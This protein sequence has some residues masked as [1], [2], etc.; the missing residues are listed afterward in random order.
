M[1]VLGVEQSEYTEFIKFLPYLHR[2]F[3]AFEVHV[4]SLEFS[5]EEDAGNLS[6]LQNAFDRARVLLRDLRLAESELG[7][8][9]P[10]SEFFRLAIGDISD[11]LAYDSPANGYALTRL[12]GEIDESIGYANSG[13][14]LPTGF[15]TQ[16]RGI[17]S[18]F[19]SHALMDRFNR[20]VSNEDYH[21][22]SYEVVEGR[23]RSDLK[24]VVSGEDLG[25]DFI[26][27]SLRDGI[28]ENGFCVDEVEEELIVQLIVAL[29][30]IGQRVPRLMDLKKELVRDFLHQI[31]QGGVGVHRSKVNILNLKLNQEQQAREK[32]E[33]NL[34]QDALTG[35]NNKAYWMKMVD[36]NVNLS[37]L[38]RLVMVSIDLNGF[39]AVND[40]GVSG[41]LDGHNLGD[42]VLQLAARKMKSKLRK[43]SR[44]TLCR[45]GGDEFGLF[46]D[47]DISAEELLALLSRLDEALQEVNEELSITYE[48]SIRK[49]QPLRISGSF[50]AVRRSPEL[51]KNP[52]DVFAEADQAMYGNKR[53]FGD[54]VRSA[55]HKRGIVLGPSFGEDEGRYVPGSEGF[56]R[57]YLGVRRRVRSALGRLLA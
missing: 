27:D 23:L 42:K 22:A 16:L 38:R 41:D 28:R 7:E 44:Y 20:G 5:E 50:G 53:G 37:N 24:E 34:D 40:F 36:K 21:F 13:E 49:G 26:L 6:V 35:L 2:D 32:I 33:N 51:H 11:F 52:A 8:E 15:Y 48:S 54:H 39:K 47:E 31:S 19:L 12:Y 46:I 56:Y 1:A 43:S 30:R 45:L 29:S 18:L 9:D 10:N 25:L 3:I 14:I 17:P 57:E 4:A 55:D